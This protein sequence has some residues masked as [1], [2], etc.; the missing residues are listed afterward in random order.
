MKTKTNRTLQRPLTEQR[1]RAFLDELARHGVAAEAA[2]VASPHSQERHGC[3]STFRAERARDPEFAADWDAALEAADARLLKEA[4]RRAV[5]GVERGVFQKA[6][7][8]LDHDGK[9]ATELQYSDRLMELLLKSRFPNEFI[10]RR[11]IEHSGQL[12][13][14]HRGLI[15]TGHD[16]LALN[17]EERRQLMGILEKVAEHR[18]ELP[19]PTDQP[20]TALPSPVVEEAPV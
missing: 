9:P 16:L 7:R 1:K 18:G 11:A 13:H 3:L 2:R 6:Q 17:A 12:D 20:M 15:L 19:A 14:T 10:E 8:V 4:H 5:E